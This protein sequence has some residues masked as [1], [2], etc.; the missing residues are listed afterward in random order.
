MPIRSLSLLALV[1]VLF[2][3]LQLLAVL[4]PVQLL[5]PAWQFQLSNALI[6]AATPPLLALA[7]LLVAGQLAPADPLIKKRRR[8]FSQLAVVA[9]IGYLLLLPLHLSAGLRQQSAVSSAQMERFVGPEKRLAKLRQLTALASSNAELNA[10]LQQLSGPVLRPS[11]LA[12]P[13]P[14]LKAQ[15]KAVFD[16]AQIQINRERAALPPA[17]AARAI[18]DLARN[19]LSC[20]LLATAYA[21]FAR[22]PGSTLSLLEESQRSLQRLRRR[23]KVRSSSSVSDTDYIRHLSGKD[24]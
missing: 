22:R 1:F 20:L 5:D 19:S 16:Q 11:D 24:D 17:T 2:F 10:G 4:L 23:F 13:L 6:N 7:L 8:L 9:A 18:P 3:A 12:Q 21:A 15:V 14:M